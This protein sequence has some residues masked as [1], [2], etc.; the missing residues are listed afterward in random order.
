MPTTVK[1]TPEGSTLVWGRTEY[2]ANFDVAHA[3]DHVGI[4]GTTLLA[5]GEHWNFAV[6]PSVTFGSGDQPAFVPALRPLPAM[7]TTGTPRSHPH[8]DWYSESE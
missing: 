7:T 5:D 3:S 4:T 1:W 6:A 2:S 8:L